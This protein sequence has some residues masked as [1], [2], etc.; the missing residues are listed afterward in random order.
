MK[1][2]KTAQKNVTDLDHGVGAGEQLLLVKRLHGHLLHHTLQPRERVLH[3]PAEV[4]HL[5]ATWAALLPATPCDVCFC[6]LRMV[7][8][9]TVMLM[10]KTSH[11][12]VNFT[13]SSMLV[14]SSM[15]ARLVMPR[16]GK[17]MVSSST[18]VARK[19]ISKN[20][21]CHQ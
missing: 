18:Q 10:V 7:M 21:V 14:L 16:V 19:Q 12:V 15:M 3:R 20:P 6:V 17:L 1:T 5:T 8:V 4:D 13:V 11:M 2:Q 9:L